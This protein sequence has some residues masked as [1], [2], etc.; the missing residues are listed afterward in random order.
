MTRSPAKSRSTQKPRMPPAEPSIAA[1]VRRLKHLEDRQAG[2]IDTIIAFGEIIDDAIGKVDE[3]FDESASLLKATQVASQS[4]ANEV[5]GLMSV[6]VNPSQDR[7]AEQKSGAGRYPSPLATLQTRGG[8]PI[9]AD[10]A[11]IF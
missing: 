5:R 1:L 4:L 7:H 3:R 2:L 6:H 8:R 9:N 10:A 11:R